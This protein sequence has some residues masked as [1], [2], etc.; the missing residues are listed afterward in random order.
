MRFSSPQSNNETH[1]KSTTTSRIGCEQKRG[2]CPRRADGAAPVHR[3]PPP[4]IRRLLTTMTNTGPARPT[5][6]NVERFSR[7][8]A[9]FQ[10][11]PVA[12]DTT[13]HLAQSVQR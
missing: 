12:F 4:K 1:H 11:L 2:H 8:V 10:G 3:R 5:D 6:W 9:S 13:G 7:H